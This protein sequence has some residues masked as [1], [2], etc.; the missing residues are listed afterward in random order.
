[1]A[2]KS[3]EMPV[4]LTFLILIGL[5][6]TVVILGIIFTIKNS[7]SNYVSRTLS[8]SSYATTIVETSV[9]SIDKVALD[10]ISCYRNRQIGLC[11]LIQYTGTKSF[12][13]SDLISKVLSIDKNVVIQRCDYT[14]TPNSYV[15]VYYSQDGDYVYLKVQ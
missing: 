4:N 9:D 7:A 8:N 6:V 11:Y 13:C 2:M 12:T 15:L 3:L 5:I 14:I 10:V 1:M